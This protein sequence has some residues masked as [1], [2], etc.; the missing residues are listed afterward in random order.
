MAKKPITPKSKIISIL[1]K[2]IWLYS[3]ERAERLKIDKRKCWGCG[4]TDKL[5]VH[6]ISPVDFDKIIA[7]IR[8]QLLVKP[9]KLM[10]LCKSCHKLEHDS[11]KNEPQDTKA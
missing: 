5:N 4:S 9:K 7:V 8:R 1:R 6:H 11:L 3:R 2:Y 10:V